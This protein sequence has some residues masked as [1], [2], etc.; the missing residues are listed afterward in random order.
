[1]EWHSALGILGGIVYNIGYIPYVLQILKGKT[2]PNLLSWVGWFFLLVI[3]SSAQLAGGATWS[4]ALHIAAAIGCGI[5]TL[6]AFRYGYA[7]FTI[8]EKLCFLLAALAI[9]VWVVTDEPLYGLIL[10]VAADSILFVPTMVKTWRNPQS[11]ALWGWLLFATG[12]LIAVG[13]ATVYNL[14]NLLYPIALFFFNGSVVLI[15]L[16]GR[17]KKV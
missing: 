1:M 6:V 4:V 11:E 14:N 16:R 15:A 8:L 17:I 3:G 2:R 10:A 13:G 5:T 12:S 9:G 7:T